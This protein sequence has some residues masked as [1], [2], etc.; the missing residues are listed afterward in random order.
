MSPLRESPPESRRARG[1]RWRFFLLSPD[2]D[3]EPRHVLPARCGTANF[4]PPDV[5]G[6]GEQETVGLFDV[7]RVKN[8]ARGNPERRPAL[9][10]LLAII[11]SRK[12]TKGGR[13]RGGEKKREREMRDAAE[14]SCPDNGRPIAKRVPYRRH[15]RCSTPNVAPRALTAL[16]SLAVHQGDK[17][18]RRPP[19][20]L[21]ATRLRGTARTI[22]HSSRP[23]AR[24]SRAALPLAPTRPTP[25]S[26]APPPLAAAGHTEA[27][28]SLAFPPPPAD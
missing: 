5:V 27:C 17:Q 21:P 4:F 13:E 7:A 23:L 15:T 18:T 10:Q 14:I 25:L 9:A 24:A 2:G 1:D 16:A 26:R 28:A 20:T 12:R 11:Y 19:L 3:D 8:G 22:A 6:E